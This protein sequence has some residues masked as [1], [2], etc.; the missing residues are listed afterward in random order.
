MIHELLLKLK[1]Q[2]DDNSIE[3]KE[4]IRKYGEVFTPFSL[5]K[6]MI[7]SIPSSKITYKTKFFD[8]SAGMGQF[9]LVILGTLLIK[10][11]KI[12]KTK[13][14]YTIYKHI[15]EKQIYMAELQQSSAQK[16]VELFNSPTF[17]IEPLKL[18]LYVGDVLKMPYDYFDLTY[19][20]RQE[21]YK[22]NTI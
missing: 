8:P 16:I 13:D 20:Q 3:T 10:H 7:E 2:V 12:S 6:K 22:E 15:L 17:I 19:E 5:I 4:K 11:Y 1:Q 9:P 18:N 21:K 14:I